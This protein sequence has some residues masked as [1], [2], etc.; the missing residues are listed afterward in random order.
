[1]EQE[2]NHEKGP[3]RSWA[4]NQMGNPNSIMKMTA[5]VSNR[6]N[7]LPVIVFAALVTLMSGCQS[8]PEASSDL[9]Q[10]AL[11]FTPP[12]G[13]AGL[14]VIRPWHYGGSAVNWGV[15]LDY[16]YFGT[17]ETSS[18]LY[19]AILPGKHFLRMGASGDSSVKTFIAKAGE[20]YYFSIN[21]SILGP[22]FDQNPE[23][24]GQ[25]YVRKFKMSGATSYKVPFNP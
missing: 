24:D 1:V 17:L 15:R 4:R 8:V 23:A 5:Q 14:Y 18:Y 3:R 13:M 11:S 22:V 25:K 10:K 2:E 21:L 20:N 7:L 12:S 9:K 16:Q 19:S 6:L